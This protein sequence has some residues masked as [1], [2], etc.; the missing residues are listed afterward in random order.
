[1]KLYGIDDNF[2]TFQ[3]HPQ[4]LSF[5]LYSIKYKHSNKALKNKINLHFKENN[6]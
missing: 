6:V 3:C 1:M 5:L 2:D 4:A